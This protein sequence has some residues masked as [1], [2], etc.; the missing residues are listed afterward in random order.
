MIASYYVGSF[1]HLE[2]DPTIHCI[3]PKEGHPDSMTLCGTPCSSYFIWDHETQVNCL[4]C[5]KLIE[6]SNER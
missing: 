1:Q 4:S 2:Q 5:L 3:L 6:E